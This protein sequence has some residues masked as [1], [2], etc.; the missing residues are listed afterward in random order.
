LGLMCVGVRKKKRRV[1]VGGRGNPRQCREEKFAYSMRW[2][3]QGE[4]ETV[5]EFEE[6]RG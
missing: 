1:L 4:K 3:V 5:G 2:E 6:E